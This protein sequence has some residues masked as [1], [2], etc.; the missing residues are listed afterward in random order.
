MMSIRALGNAGSGG[1]AAQ[2]ASH[3]YREKSADYYIKNSS[4]G[5]GQDLDREGEWIGRGSQK[6]G[7][8]EGPDREQLQL[9]LGGSLAG[10]EVQNAG[11]PDR[12]MGWDMTFSAP[13]SVS[14]AWAFADPKHR[15][16]I[17]KAHQAAARAAHAYLESQTTTR[18][19]SG[20]SKTEAAYLASAIFTHYTSRAGD[21][22]LH[23]HIVTPNF[24]VRG[25]G[26]VGTVESKSFYDLKLTA[27]ALY[28]AEL[29]HRTR[30]L[31]YAIEKGE[32]G[33][34]RLKEVS[35]GMERQFSKRDQEIDREVG[36]QG[37]KTYAGTRGVVISTRLPKRY[38]TLAEREKVWQKEAT[39]AGLSRP[40]PSLPRPGKIQIEREEMK[41]TIATSASRLTDQNS[42]FHEHDLVR[43]IA[44]SSYGRMNARQAQALVAMAPNG[45][46]VLKI[47]RNKKGRKVLST[48]EMAGIERDMKEDARALAG[49][50]GFKVEASQTIAQRP[51]LNAEQQ[52][53]VLAA[54]HEGGLVVIQGRAGTGK[55]TTLQTIREAYERGGYEVQGI[56]VSGQAA[57]NLHKEAGI[58]SGTIASWRVNPQ[59]GERTVLVVDE[60]GMVGSKQM[61]EILKIAR[62]AKGKVILVGDVRQLQP[63]DAGGALHAVDREVM[64]V[65]PGAS[66]Q[67]TTIHR[68]REPWMREA[69]Y[70]AARGDTAQAFKELDAHGKI[71][72]YRD[73][74]QAR[75]ALVQ[76]YLDKNAERPEEAVILTH[77]KGDATEINK[78]V[79][80]KL[81]DRGLIGENK[82]RVDNGQRCLDLAVGD[83]VMMLKNDYK[84][85][86]RNGNRGRVTKLNEKEKTIDVRLDNGEDK[87]INLSKY[88]HLDHGWASTTHKAQGATV[89][90]A[91]V[92]GHTQESMASQQATYVQI[93]RARGETKIFAVSGERSIERVGP[94]LSR[95]QARPIETKEEKDKALKEMGRSWGK[96]ASKG[97]TLDYSREMLQQIKK[98]EQS[99]S[100]GMER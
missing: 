89:E 74:P 96:D 61:G 54:T 82:L 16:E 48:L 99:R 7:L 63:I 26:T 25:D 34:F 6:L 90:R 43:E 32:R 38:T 19:G 46:G 65:R 20:G 51:F 95:E 94:E 80:E 12:Q 47:G 64:K 37:I 18:R 5:E 2:A 66:S 1:S 58:S 41:Q 76:E 8:T 27:G 30:G 31:G 9:A 57:Q 42:T 73:G 17:L 29:A 55:T 44:R 52:A 85:G 22:Q 39:D 75:K 11:K 14:V 53:A 36:K 79:R 91:Y 69:V 35:L 98:H 40:S 70:H 28:Q 81:Q 77:R 68:Q 71:Q 49:G 88:P 56:A 50:K 78:Q 72:I 3:Y 100:E 62:Q 33:T 92:Y 4:N 97:T 13:K 86:V 10:R 93:S 84:L 87:K 15:E 45:W 23:S 21:P 59:M 24:C 83:R 67:I 60:A